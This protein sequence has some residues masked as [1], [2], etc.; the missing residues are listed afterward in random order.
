MT[1]SAEAI[2][3][4]KKIWIASSRSLPGDRAFLQSGKFF[5]PGQGKSD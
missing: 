5:Q 1:G 3:S 2:Q 4:R